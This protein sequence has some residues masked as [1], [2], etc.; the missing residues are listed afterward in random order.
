MAYKDKYGGTQ[1][2]DGRIDNLRI[3]WDYEDD[4]EDKT[5]RFPVLFYTPDMD[6]NKDDPK[7]CPDHFHIALDS[8][9]KILVLRDWLTKF[10]E[11]HPDGPKGTLFS[12]ATDL[13][14]K[15]DGV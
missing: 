1:I 12:C 13:E 10:L 4:P 9:D 7:K 5:Q 3:N 15:R 6:H 14:K 2:I 8:R 11:E